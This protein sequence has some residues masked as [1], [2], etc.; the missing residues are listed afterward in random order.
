[1]NAPQLLLMQEVMV[2]VLALMLPKMEIN[3]L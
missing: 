2:L 1:M 3:N